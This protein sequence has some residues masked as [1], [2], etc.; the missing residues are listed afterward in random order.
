MKQ[1]I[2]IFAALLAA[3]IA[4]PAGAHEAAPV[5]V[6][7]GSAGGGAHAS[8]LQ[9]GIKG[10]ADADEISV[11]LDSTQ[12]QYAITSTRPINPPPPPCAQITTFQITCP[13]SDF[14][15]FSA[16]LGDSSDSFSAGPSIAVPVTISGGSGSDV[17]RGGS[18]PDTVLGGDGND[19]MLGGNGRDV[20][21]GAGGADVLKGGKGRDVLKGGHGNDRLLGGA[22]RDV[23]KQ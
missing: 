19:R 16:T 11:A 18:G 2:S 10:S 14:V 8:A 15:A 20:L 9:L 21:K 7:L 22:G 17:L 13:V 23:E 6:Q 12:T 1:G 5:S 4:A 3:A